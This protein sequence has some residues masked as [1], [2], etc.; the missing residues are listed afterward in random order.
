[1]SA[2]LQELLVAVCKCY[3][4][5]EAATVRKVCDQEATSLRYSQYQYVRGERTEGG[6]ARRLGLRKANAGIILMLHFPL[7]A[8]ARLRHALSKPTKSH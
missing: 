1:M 6:K 2:H 4:V 8:A 7:L 3:L 5:S